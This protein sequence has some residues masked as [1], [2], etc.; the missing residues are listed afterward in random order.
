VERTPPSPGVEQAD[1]GYE[2]IMETIVVGHDGLNMR[3]GLCV[4]R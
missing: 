2:W 4:G 1:P 3:S